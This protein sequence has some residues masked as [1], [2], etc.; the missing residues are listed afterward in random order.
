MPDIEAAR[1][2]YGTPSSQESVEKLEDWMDANCRDW[3]FESGALQGVGRWREI[4]ISAVFKNPM[5]KKKFTNLVTQQVRRWRFE[6]AA[7]TTE[8][9]VEMSVD[10]YAD[11]PL[12]RKMAL[13]VQTIMVDIAVRNNADK[14]RKA[15][16]R[17]QRMEAFAGVLAKIQKRAVDR[18]LKQAMDKLRNNV[19]E[20]QGLIDAALEQEFKRRRLAEEEE[21]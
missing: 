2:A 9:V 7:S 18:K 3:R 14:Q 13:Q 8:N 12:G 11:G 15:A 6:R 10:K 19:N 17:R 21:S 4:V 16:E 5:D 20:A 1:I